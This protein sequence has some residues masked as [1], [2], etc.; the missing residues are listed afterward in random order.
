MPKAGAP[1]PEIGDM[2]SFGWLRVP[3]FQLRGLRDGGAPLWAMRSRSAVVSGLRGEAA[4]GFA[5]ASG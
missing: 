1:C 4:A 3:A 2:G 5:A